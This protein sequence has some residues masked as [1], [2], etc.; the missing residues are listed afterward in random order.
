MNGNI[1]WS[2]PI[3][4]FWLLIKD[5]FLSESAQRT[6][7]MEFVSLLHIFVRIPNISDSTFS[8]SFYSEAFFNLLSISSEYFQSSWIVLLLLLIFLLRAAGLMLTMPSSVLEQYLL[9]Y[10]T[11][12]VMRHIQTL[13]LPKGSV[14]L[15]N[16]SARLTFLFSTFRSG[17]TQLFFVMRCSMA[18]YLPSIFQTGNLAS[19]M[20]FSVFSF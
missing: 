8:K 3:K 12:S 19:Q 6:S 9:C 4:I 2:I 7:F 10:I 17:L 1:F 13:Q 15:Y 14:C 18:N 20:Q 5:S 11:F 16:L